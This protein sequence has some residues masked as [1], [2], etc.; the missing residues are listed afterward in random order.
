MQPEQDDV[1]PVALVEAFAAGDE[2]ALAAVYTRWSP[3]VYSV[4][5]AALGSVDEAER[6]TQDRRRRVI[7][8]RNAVIRVRGV[9]VLWTPYFAHADPTAER[10]SG[11]LVPRI[12]VSN[13]RGLSCSC[14]MSSLP[15][16][17][18]NRSS[19]PWG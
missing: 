6:V 2:R 16:A 7:V 3:L 9:P 5:L 11:L 14:S 18:W 1:D 19:G 13:R 8:Y 10:A 15:W 17:G 12:Q 4:A